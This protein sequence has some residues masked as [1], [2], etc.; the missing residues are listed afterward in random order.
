MPS[1]PAPHPRGYRG[2]SAVP[3][4]RAAAGRTAASTHLGLGTS[5]PHALVAGLFIRR[6]LRVHQHATHT[7]HERADQTGDHY[8]GTCL[9]VE[10]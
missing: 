1:D 10:P 8:R 4:A 6:R 7:S 2:A 5:G 9:L 3:A